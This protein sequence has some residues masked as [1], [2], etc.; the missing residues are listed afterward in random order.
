MGQEG[1]CCHCELCLPAERQ[2]LSYTLRECERQEG[3]W[4]VSAKLRSMPPSVSPLPGDQKNKPSLGFRFLKRPELF[5]F[6]VLSDCTAL[7]VKGIYFIKKQTSERQQYRQQWLNRNCVQSTYARTVSLNKDNAQYGRSCPGMGGKWPSMHSDRHLPLFIHWDM[8]FGFP[9]SLDACST[10]QVPRAG[11][12]WLS[13][14][15]EAGAFKQLLP[16]S[17]CSLL[18]ERGSHRLLLLRYIPRIAT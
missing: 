2:V 10:H 6:T 18:K 15:K 12:L 16:Q 1:H 7:L 17:S 8:D 13:M 9:P 5:L 4:W 3:T 14:Q 11:N